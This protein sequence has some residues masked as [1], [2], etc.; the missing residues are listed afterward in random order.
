MVDEREPG[1][2]PDLVP[3]RSAPDKACSR[4]LERKPLTP[5][6][7]FRRTASA[8]GFTS[9]C[10]ECDRRRQRGSHDPQQAVVPAAVRGSAASEAIPRRCPGCTQ[11]K[12]LSVYIFES[13]V[14]A[15]RIRALVCRDCSTRI[16]LCDDSCWY[17]LRLVQIAAG[18]PAVQATESE[19]RFRI[20]GS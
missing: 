1:G 15:Q 10:R 11:K 19:V 3:H 20:G 2:P 7:F 17:L 18:D 5:E 13:T 12:L 8:D 14:T 4:C 16:A 9:L 6:F